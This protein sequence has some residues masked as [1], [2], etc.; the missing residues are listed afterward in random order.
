MDD[1]ALAVLEFPAVLQRL[2]SLTSFSAGR[3]AALALRPLA[4]I[5]LVTRRQRQTGEAVHLHRMATTAS[6]GG[7]RD[8]RDL[9]WGAERGQVLTAGDL[10]DVAS[11]CR[12]A[13]Q[14]QRT[15]TRQV[16]DA[17]LLAQ[18]ASGIADLGPLRGL[19]EDAIDEGGTV[20]DS[21][22]AELAQIRR[23]LTEAHSRLQQRLQA[24]LSNSGVANA[25]Q[26][27]IIVMRDG[28]YVLPVKADFRG[29]VRGVVHDTSSS[30]Q[31]VYVE[32]LAVVD[33]ANR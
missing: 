14:V 30:G 8:V 5:E 25:L 20:R 21:A 16:E 29:S 31:T 24:M 12:A 26:E 7:A 18:V 10:I 13:G 9:A 15:L 28:R 2:A 17:P 27:P 11:L 6:M 1:H 32:P 4:D 33:L 23:E 3:E 22:S 19:I